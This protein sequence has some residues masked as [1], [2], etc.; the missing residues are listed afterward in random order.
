MYM[1]GAATWTGPLLR[2]EI[3]FMRGTSFPPADSLARCRLAVTLPPAQVAGM[4]TA[5][6]HLHAV[7]G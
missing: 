7:P 2:M 3:G 1:A 4:G 6:P 5:S